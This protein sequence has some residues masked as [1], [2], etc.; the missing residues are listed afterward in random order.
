MKIARSFLN[1]FTIVLS[2]IIFYIFLVGVFYYQTKSYA[3]EKSQEKIEDLLLNVE[4]LR[5][6]NSNFQKEEIYKLQG[7]GYIYDEYFSPK[8]LSS[9][10]I[11]KEV[12]K[13]YNELRLKQNKAPIIIR[14]ASSN[15][16]NPDN[17]ASK[18]ENEI[19]DKF[20]NQTIDKYQEII[21][22][23][24]EEAIYFAIPTKVTTAECIKCHS[25]PSLAPADLLKLYGDSAGF[26][27]HNGNIRALLS[28]VYPISEEL[29]VGKFYFYIISLATLGVFIIIGLLSYRFLGIIDEKQDELEDINKYLED[30]IQEQTQELEQKSEYLNLIFNS[31][32]NIILVSDGE[33]LVFAN[34]TF[35]EIFNKCDNIDDFKKYYNS[36]GEFIQT[37]DKK[38][39]NN[40]FDVFDYLDKNHKLEFDINHKIYYFSMTTT[41]IHFNNN[42]LFLHILADITELE[43]TK[44]TLEELSIKDELTSLYNRRFFNMTYEKEL[45][46]ATRNSDYF[47]FA[48]I[49]IDYFKNYNDILGH[50]SGDEVLR[51][52]SKVMRELFNRS[53]DYVF[54]MGGEEFGIIMIGL[55]PSVAYAYLQKLQLKIKE[56]Y[57]PH[58]K[59][60]IS[61]YLTISIGL[62]VSTVSVD[63]E[64]DFYKEADKLLYKAKEVRDCIVSNFRD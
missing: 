31:S 60:D 55:D 40:K 48:V 18:R 23:D 7:E 6:F 24:G 34:D 33:H 1:R 27:E 42:Q 62:F 11:S 10:Y 8:L 39:V 58:P 12:N 28:T 5:S 57:I 41:K 32:P 20:N 36:F 46:R 51:E 15:P 2:A 4:A 56:L 54:R 50:I 9:T 17:L 61:K 30:K 45:K 19:L 47:S 3:I 44:K 38:F 52:V 21:K 13:I 26:Y 29:E 53:S 16:R 49:D 14:F 37:H 63:G 59:S 43:I 25:N 64:I 22:L 35:F